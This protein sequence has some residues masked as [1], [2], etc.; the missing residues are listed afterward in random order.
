MD[1]LTVTAAQPP[2]VPD[3]VEANVAAHADVVRRARTRVVVFP[4]LSLTG[5]LIDAPAIEP[6]DARLEPLLDACAELGSLAL[7]GA[8]VRGDDGAR[9]IG[10][11]A[12]DARGVEIAYRKM[13]LGEAEAR[14][15]APG[16]EPVALEVD[17]RRLGLAVCKDTRHPEHAAATAEL[18]I[19]AYVAAVLDHERDAAVPSQRAR[20]VVRDHGLW[21]VVASFAGPA[22]GGYELSAGRSAIWSP[23]GEAVAQAGCE[24]GALA[25]ATL[26]ARAVERP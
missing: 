19:D 1:P 8:P 7:V 12:A 17:G 20:R 22:G 13:W 14:H 10:I 6:G 21:V 4:E 16:D 24:P 15:F 9:S 23:E 5:Y 2:C 3:D 11:L 25:R 26:T 18:G